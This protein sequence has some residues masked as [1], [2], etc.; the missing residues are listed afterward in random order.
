[1]AGGSGLIP[2]K[3]VMDEEVELKE[4]VE[5]T[6][7]LSSCTVSQD[8]F[9]ILEGSSHSQRSGSVQDAGEGKCSFCF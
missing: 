3:E 1:G 8:L 7:G 5:H 6:A 9:S 4:D 2:N